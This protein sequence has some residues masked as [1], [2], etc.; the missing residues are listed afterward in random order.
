M[1]ALVEVGDKDY[2]VEPTIPAKAGWFDVV[3]RECVACTHQRIVATVY[4]EV[5][6]QKIAQALTEM[7]GL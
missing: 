3:K 4:R 2:V 1:S 7:E 5:D 6:A